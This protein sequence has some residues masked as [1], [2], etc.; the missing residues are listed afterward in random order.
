MSREE[1]SKTIDFV[2]QAVRVTSNL[3]KKV[4]KDYLD[5]KTQHKKLKYGE[6]AKKGKLESIEVTENNI[7]DFLKTARK[8]DIDYAL[9]RDSSTIPPTYHIFFTASNTETFKRAFSEYAVKAQKK[10][11]EKS[12]SQIVNRGQIKE[13]AKVISQKSAELDKEKHHSK[14]TIAGR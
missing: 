10:I 11:N 6:L 5:N 13:N 7:G 2:V 12:V 4:L 9:K 1:T 3:L 14:S 8:Y